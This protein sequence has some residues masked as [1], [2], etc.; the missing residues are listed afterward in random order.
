MYLEGKKQPSKSFLCEIKSC[1]RNNMLVMIPQNVLFRIKKNNLS[2]E[3][4][5]HFV[6]VIYSK[7]TYVLMAIF[8]IK[9]CFLTLNFSFVI[10][11]SGKKRKLVNWGWL[12][13]LYKVK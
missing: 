10:I 6:C 2:E 13:E 9:L 4:Q 7:G 8:Y 3:K 5:I 12:H 11:S 1:F